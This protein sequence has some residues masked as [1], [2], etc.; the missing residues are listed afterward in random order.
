MIVF[1]TLVI[2]ALFLLALVGTDSEGDELPV[3]SGCL[4]Q[5]AT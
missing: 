4:P 1:I 3:G 5:V 2:V